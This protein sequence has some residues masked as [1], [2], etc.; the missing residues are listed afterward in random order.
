MRTSRLS[1]KPVKTSL[2]ALSTGLSKP[3]PALT[4]CEI[5][6]KKRGWQ[7]VGEFWDCAPP[8]CT[9]LDHAQRWAAAL[10]QAEIG[11]TR[12]IV[13]SRLDDV[14]PDAAAYATLTAWAADHC[15]FVL[16][17]DGGRYGPHHL[18]GPAP[19]APTAKAA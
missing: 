3:T 14:A 15:T 5:L 18:I 16:F 9:R 17:V 10:K 4:D 7:P 12:G 6:A 1:L 19:S 13:A 11:M 2:Y 8:G